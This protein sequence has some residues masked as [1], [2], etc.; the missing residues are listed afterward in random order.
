MYSSVCGVYTYVAPS[1]ALAEV[2]PPFDRDRPVRVYV[3]TV[4]PVISLSIME[5]RQCVEELACCRRYL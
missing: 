4:R 1:H 2:D 5:G 3:T